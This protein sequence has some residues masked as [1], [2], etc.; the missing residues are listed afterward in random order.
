[1]S[2]PT[3]AARCSWASMTAPPTGASPLREDNIKTFDWVNVLTPRELLPLEYYGDPRKAKY[4]EP[5]VYQLNREIVSA[6][7]AAV[8]QSLRIHE[9]R[10]IRFN[11][12]QIS[13]RQLL[14]GNGW[15]DSIFN[16]V[17]SV[18]RDFDAAWAG[19]SVLL[20]DFAQAVLSIE[21]LA[22]MV[23]QH[24]GEAIKNR[25]QAF[26]HGTV[27]DQHRAD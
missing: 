23:S 3:A 13:K 25:A 21:G 8:R 15:G 5:A 9:S 14:E 17:A 27:D 2:G 20:T 6:E 18:V 19:A 4:G 24:G 7:R 10:I 26:L 1:M 11:G 22:E 12:V 16:R